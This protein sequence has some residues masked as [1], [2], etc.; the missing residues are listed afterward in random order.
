M[1]SWCNTQ[2]SHTNYSQPSQRRPSNASTTEECDSLLSSLAE[3]SD[4]EF[5]KPNDEFVTYR[6]NT[7]NKNDRKD[8]EVDTSTSVF[9]KCRKLSRES[10]ILTLPDS[11]LS[12][13]DT[14]KDSAKEKSV[15]VQVDTRPNASSDYCTCDSTSI[16]ILERNVIESSV[17]DDACGSFKNE[18]SRVK[19][20]SVTNSPRSVESSE[21]TFVTVSEVYKYLD[22]EEGVTLYEKRLLKTPAR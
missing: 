5:K 12:E 1:R 8:Q 15:E 19:E 20:G 14:E 18:S 13:Y 17:E 3:S 10:G 2:L 21:L 7:N 11:V 22:P 9:D 4:F 6:K 16:N